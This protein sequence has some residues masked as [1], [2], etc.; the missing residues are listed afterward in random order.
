MEQIEI[1]II[2][3]NEN[4]N[5][6]NNATLVIIM[7]IVGFMMLVAIFIGCYNC[8]ML[9]VKRKLEHDMEC[10]DHLELDKSKMDLQLP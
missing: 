5:S 10:K 6:V 2:N 8:Y 3:L 1:E 7:S 9:K 4:M